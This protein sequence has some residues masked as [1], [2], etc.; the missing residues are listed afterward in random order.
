MIFVTVEC[1]RI[2]RLA[3]DP[4]ERWQAENIGKRWATSTND[5]RGAIQC[6]NVGTQVPDGRHPTSASYRPEK[7][8]RA[9]GEI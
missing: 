9:G 1:Q 6:H 3:R 5:Q 4:P 7:E 2:L 8:D